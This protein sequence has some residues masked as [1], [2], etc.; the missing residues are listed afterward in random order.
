MEFMI[1]SIFG[2]SVKYMYTCLKWL[3]Q[4]MIQ[5]TFIPLAIFRSIVFIMEV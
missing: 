5:I 1:T 2:T 4:V 3:M